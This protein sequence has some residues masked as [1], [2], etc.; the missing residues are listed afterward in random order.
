M[1]PGFDWLVG[2][3]DG[4]VIGDAMTFP[5]AL[6]FFRKALHSLSGIVTD[7]SA[8][9][10]LDVVLLG[11]SLERFCAEWPARPLAPFSSRAFG[12]HVSN[13]DLFGVWASGPLVAA[14]FWIGALADGLGAARP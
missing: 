8:A 2:M 9:A 10:S 3:L 13:A 6:L 11:A 4:L 12:T 1:A 14:R 7:V 5:A